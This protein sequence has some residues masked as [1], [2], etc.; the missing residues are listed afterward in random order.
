MNLTF[1]IINLQNIGFN[2]T[3]S[4]TI[5]DFLKIQIATEVGVNDRCE[6]TLRILKHNQYPDEFPF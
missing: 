4:N 3:M 6:N 2:I 1:A 5:T